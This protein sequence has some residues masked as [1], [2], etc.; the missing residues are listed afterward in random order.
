M[1]KTVNPL[2]PLKFEW[3]FHTS[4]T[5][6]DAPRR[7]WRNDW[8]FDQFLIV[9]SDQFKMIEEVCDMFSISLNEAED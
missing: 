2:V 6:S 5:H 3:R 8:S 1:T 9:S 4:N 7:V